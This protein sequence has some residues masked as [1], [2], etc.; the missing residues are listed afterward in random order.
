MLTYITSLVLFFI[1]KKSYIAILVLMTLEGFNLPIP[2]E[3]IMPFAGFLANKGIISFWMAVF[4]GALG[5]VFGSLL[6]YF[7][8]EWI[9]VLREKSNILKKILKEKDLEKANKWFLKYGKISVFLGRV[10]PLI[11]TFISLP[12]GLA[13]MPLTSFI[14]LTFLGSFIWSAFLTYLGYVLSENW[15]ILE[16]YFRKVDYFLLI[17]IL[18]LIL[19]L[20]WKKLRVKSFN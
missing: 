10:I 9:L 14:P 1:E 19:V 12:A 17:L 13:K 16:Y 3:T 15:G 5:T 20:V 18:A 11:R 2:S 6:S 7:L 8:A 4:F